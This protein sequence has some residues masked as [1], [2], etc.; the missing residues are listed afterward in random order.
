MFFFFGRYQWARSAET[1][2]IMATAKLP[3]LSGDPC[4][5]NLSTRVRQTFEKNEVESENDGWD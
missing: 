5:Q 4:A 2:P 1:N 3:M